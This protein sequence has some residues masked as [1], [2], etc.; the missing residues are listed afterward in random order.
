MINSNTN[1][2]MTDEDDTPAI[3]KQANRLR[4]KLADDEEFMAKL[5]SKKGNNRL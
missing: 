3:I 4:K 2:N 1:I 5:A